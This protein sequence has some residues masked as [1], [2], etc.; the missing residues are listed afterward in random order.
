[1]DAT[2]KVEPEEI[3]ATAG[4]AADAL[5]D[6]LRA[7]VAGP[8]RERMAGL[9]TRIAEVEH[10]TE[11]REALIAAVSPILGDAIR[12]QVREDRDALIE[13]LYPIIGQLIG[14]AVAESI[15]DLARTIDNRM[16]TSLSPAY[17]MRRARARAAGVSD[18][19]LTLRDALPFQVAELFLVHR[20]S[21]LLLLHLSRPAPGELPPE[22]NSDLVSGMLTAIRDFAQDAFGRGQEGQLD[23]IQYG[24]RRILIEACQHVYLAVVVDGIEP[25]GF[26]AKLREHTVEVENSY[27]EILK[28]YDGD[29]SHFATVQPT[30]TEL[31]AAGGAEEPTGSLSRGQRTV[32]LVLAGVLTLCLAGACFGGVALARSALSR[33]AYVIVVTATPGPT[34]TRTPSPTAT[35]TPTAT[36]T[37]TRT[38]TPS[39]TPSSTA[40][41]APTATRTLGPAPLSRVIVVANLR[42]QPGLASQ[43]LEQASLGSSY[44]V[45]G[46]DPTGG[47]LKV[48]CTT[49]GED[50]WLAAA[51]VTI[52][53]SMED[54]PIV[55][56]R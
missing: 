55:Q 8:D 56:E 37:P 17:L 20:E 6:D 14:R 49:R 31:L 11:D 41:L 2:N 29:A 47:W 48:C 27:N 50:G 15:R 44:R 13:S 36:S 34:A 21:G 43:V 52:E 19:E 12:K 10:R 18:A 7:I 22:D 45:L 51:L 30:M 46:R 28:R 16:R 26:R 1:V 42:A 40:T 5:L 4:N 35:R 53:G 3:S 39:A 9:E 32:V 54:V 23:E 24:N 38:V 25:A 33:P